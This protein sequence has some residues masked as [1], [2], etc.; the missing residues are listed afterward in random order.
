[1]LSQVVISYL[2]MI[3]P[4]MITMA[5]VNF[6]FTGFDLGRYRFP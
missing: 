5:W 4:N 3:V 2:N 1:M 6:F